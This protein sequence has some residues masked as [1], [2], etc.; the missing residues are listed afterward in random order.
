MN[1]NDFYSKVSQAAYEKVEAEL[2]AT[3]GCHCSARMRNAGTEYYEVWAE[4]YGCPIHDEQL[5]AFGKL[6]A[7][8]AT[9]PGCLCRAQATNMGTEYFHTGIDSQSCPI[10]GPLYSR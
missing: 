5:W 10:H 2:R 4:T 7:E 6:R 1:D 8:L 9:S 3:P